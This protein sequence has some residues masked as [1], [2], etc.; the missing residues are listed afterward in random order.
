M[1]VDLNSLDFWFPP[2]EQAG[3]PVPRTVIVRT[4]NDLTPVLDGLLPDGFELLVEQLKLAGQAVGGPPFFLRTGHGS[5][6]H[7]WK[8]TCY[9]D[10]LD[11]V[12]WHVAALVEW[13][14]TVDLLGLPTE[15]WAARQLIDTVPLFHAFERMPIT[16]EFRLFVRDDQV[17]HV[18][19]YWPADAIARGGHPDDQDW[20]TKLEQ[21]SVLLDDERTLLIELA[22]R[23][24]SAVG[25]G[26]WSVD[27]LEDRAGSWWLTDMAEG[28]KS[29]RYGG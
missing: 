12:G 10:D 19:A 29:F 22:A 9:V 27:M 16:R 5:G 8:D 1:T 18:Q 6:K 7:G 13:S 20:Q 3:L 26:F 15:V 23:A 28:D 4:S 2:L 25:G 21:A 24:V 14:C 11:A 17:E